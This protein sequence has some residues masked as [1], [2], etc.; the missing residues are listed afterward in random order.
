[1]NNP[2]MTK[3]TTLDGFWEWAG[4]GQPT[5]IFENDTIKMYYA[6]G[7]IYYVTLRT[8]DRSATAKCVLLR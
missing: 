3:D 2:V 5:C 7:G 4:V 1:V 6:A 8:G